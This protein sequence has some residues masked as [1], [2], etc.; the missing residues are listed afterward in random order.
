MMKFAEVGQ[1]FHWYG[2]DHALT[3]IAIPTGWHCHLEMGDS[4]VMPMIYQVPDRDHYTNPR[5]LWDDKLWGKPFQNDPSSTVDELERHQV[6]AQVAW[7]IDRF[8]PQDALIDY[9]FSLQEK[10]L[11]KIIGSLIK[12]GSVEGIDSVTVNEG[13]ISISYKGCIFG[14]AV[15]DNRDE[16]EGI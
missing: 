15:L 13:I 1:R 3:V 4:P 12:E 2:K 5:A 11:A 10:D 14:L 16:G 9:D 8:L 7:G 6:I